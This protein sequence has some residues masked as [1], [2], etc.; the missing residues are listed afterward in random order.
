MPVLPITIT[1]S[2]MESIDLVV[3]T[4]QS[5]KNAEVFNVLQAT[6]IRNAWQTVRQA[7]SFIL[8]DH[9]YTVPINTLCYPKQKCKQMQ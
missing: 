4:I 2:Q 7:T 9:R 8:Q 6:F 1:S 3:H 5:F